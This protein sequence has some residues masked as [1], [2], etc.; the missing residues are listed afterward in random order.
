MDINFPLP[1][2]VASSNRIAYHHS[3]QSIL[4][5]LLWKDSNWK[6]KSKSVFSELKFGSLYPIKNSWKSLPTV[7]FIFGSLITVVQP[8][9]TLIMILVPLARRLC[10][11]LVWKIHEVDSLMANQWLYTCT[12]F[13]GNPLL[14]FKLI[15][16]TL[17]AFRTLLQWKH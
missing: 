2:V 1:F 11:S 15:F 8:C 17:S 9:F 6:K 5:Y 4:I 16:S 3:T 12:H 10:R 7:Q 13:R 14:L